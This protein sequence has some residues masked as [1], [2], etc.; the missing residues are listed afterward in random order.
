MNTD[1][2]NLP[3]NGGRRIGDDRRNFI[4]TSHLPESR[5]DIERRSGIDRRKSLRID[6]LQEKTFNH[7]I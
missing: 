6:P 3:D 4:Y 1:K 5:D 7:Y 2:Y